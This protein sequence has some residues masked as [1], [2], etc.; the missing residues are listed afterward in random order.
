MKCTECD[1]RRVIIRMERQWWGSSR[2]GFD[3]GREVERLY[4]CERCKGSGVE[5]APEPISAVLFNG[6][7]IDAPGFTSETFAA[8][9]AKAI[10]VSTLPI[11][12]AKV[13]GV[14]VQSTRTGEHYHV[15]R[16]RCSCPG[17]MSHGHCY[18]R[19]AVLYI[20]DVVGVDVSRERILGFD[21]TGQPVTAAERR[22][23]LQEVA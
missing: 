5:P 11:N 16:E 21:Q 10:A 4:Q 20:N 3:T 13:G 19:A 6:A 23:Q 7:A 22:R 8:G 15:T 18:H 14:L 2:N 17:G 1:G 12:P 9:V